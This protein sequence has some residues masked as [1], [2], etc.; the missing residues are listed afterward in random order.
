MQNFDVIVVGAGPGGSTAA[1]FAA[2]AGLNV[3]L[4]DKATFPR[5]KICGDAM[6]GKSMTVIKRL[7]LIETLQDA[8]SLGS[9]GVTFSGPG[10]DQVSIPFLVDENQTLAPGYIARR[11][12]FDALVFN[13]AVEAG[14]TVW[15]NTTVQELLLEGKQA[16]GVAVMRAQE[17]IAVYAPLVIGADGAYSVVAK[18]LGFKQLDEKHYSGGLRVYYEGVTGFQPDNQIELHFVDEAIPGYFWI[19]PMAN[20]MAN[21]GIGMLS[22][23]IKKRNVKLKDL[24]DQMIKHPRFA[25]RFA[26][27][28]QVGGVKGWGLPMGSKPRPLSGDGWVLVGDAG[29]LIDPFTG[30]GIGNA[31]ISGE[32][33][34]IWAGKALEKQDFSAAFLAG[35]EEKVLRMLKDEFWVSHWLQRLSNWKWLMNMVIA[36]ASREPEIADMIAIMLKDGK[37]RERLTQPSFYWK[38]LTA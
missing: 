11:E 3:L 5:D 2:R 27:A 21:V 36:K 31:M 4:I 19:F 28:K 17:K 6:S 7:G 25:A 37:Q 32:Q 13:K 16:K 18:G 26:E 12:V 34:G 22:A 8:E 33:A 15:Q 30:E 14:V 29:S 20:G 35:Y 10:G 38:V 24:L 9:W 1:T 23:V